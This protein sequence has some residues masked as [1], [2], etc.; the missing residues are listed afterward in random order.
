MGIISFLGPNFPGVR[1]LVLVLMSNVC[2]LVVLL[3]ILVVTWWLLLVTWCLLL[4]T[5]R[6]CLFPLLIWTFFNLL[7]KFKRKYYVILLVYSYWLYWKWIK[8]SFIKLKFINFNFNKSRYS[9]VFYG[10]AILENFGI[11]LEKSVGEA[12]ILLNKLTC[13]ANSN[14]NVLCKRLLL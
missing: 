14:W 12:Y 4:V 3:I 6:Y 11:F 8:P 5:A 7:I 1:G 2:Y 13:K 9:Q 10:I